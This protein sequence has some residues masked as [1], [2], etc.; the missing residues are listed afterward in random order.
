[1]RFPFVLA[2][3]VAL[4]A[5]VVSGNADESEDCPFFCRHSSECKECEIAKQCVSMSNLCPGTIHMTHRY[6]RSSSCAIV[7][8][9]VVGWF[10]AD[11]TEPI[12][13]T[14]A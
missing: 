1:M 12:L 8:D 2:A 13:Y 11:C 9:R 3:A 5:S 10:L 7:G 6:G 4:T 14:P